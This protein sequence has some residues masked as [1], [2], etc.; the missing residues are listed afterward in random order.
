MIADNWVPELVDYAGGVDPLGDAG[1]HCGYL[2]I[3]QLVA[4]DPDVIAIM[5]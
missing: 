5:P 4:A 2:D 3:A 1:K